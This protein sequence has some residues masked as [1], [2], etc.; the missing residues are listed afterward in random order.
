[1]YVVATYF[2]EFGENFRTIVE[3]T[4][5]RINVPI[6]ISATDLKG[7]YQTLITSIVDSHENCTVEYLIT[8]TR[9][10][11]TLLCRQHEKLLKL[12]PISRKRTGKRWGYVATLSG[13]LIA[14]KLG[15]LRNI[16]VK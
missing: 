13:K 5:E 8:Q 1:L 12:S 11:R 4:G 16:R 3:T 9:K 14:M 15:S 10:D 6:S 2:S 7:F